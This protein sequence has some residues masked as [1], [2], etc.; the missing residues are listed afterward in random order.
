MAR[1]AAAEN[2]S[3]VSLARWW[4]IAL[5]LSTAACIGITLGFFPSLIA[6]NVESRGFDTSW[7]GVL[8]AMPATAGVIVAPIAP[9][10]IARFGAL[11]TFLIASALAVIAACLFPLFSGLLSW[12]LIRFAMGVGMGIQ[13]VVSEMWV[14]RLATGPRRGMI[15]SLYVIVLSAAIAAGPFLLS[16]LGTQGHIPF[17]ATAALLIISCLPLLFATNA[18]A[19]EANKARVLS[20]VDAFLRKPSAMLIGLIDGFVFQ[21]LLVFIPLYFLRLGSPEPSALNF[22][23]L[24]CVGSVILQFFIGYMLDRTKPAMVLIVCCSLV[25]AGLVLMAE[26]RETPGLA[27]PLFI[28]MGGAAA[29]IYTAGLAAVNDGFSAEDMPSGTAAFTVLWYV[30]GLSGPVAAGYAM[31]LWNP[32]GMAAAVAAACAVLV[33]ASVVAVFSARAKA[34]VTQGS[35]G[36]QI[37]K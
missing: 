33:G 22:L 4:S 5:V 17:I 36:H 20:L 19:G 24:F 37:D 32:Y 35:S 30:G 1:R 28:I 3:E 34:T 23:T 6:L 31:D 11:R 15:L 21:T 27:W 29:A 18:V 10:A 9:R 8:A 16:K 25:I 13:W 7:N 14:N 12:F 26:V 2:R